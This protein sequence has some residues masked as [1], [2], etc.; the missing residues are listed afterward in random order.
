MLVRINA[1]RQHAQF[2]LYDLG[3]SSDVSH[4]YLQKVELLKFN[5]VG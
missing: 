5:F 1:R 3:D 2:H 4:Y